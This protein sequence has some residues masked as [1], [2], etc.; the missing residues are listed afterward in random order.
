ME[1]LPVIICIGSSAV[2]GDSLG[3]LV[4]DLLREKHNVKA[5]VYG[6]TGR[7]VNGINYAKYAEY[8]KKTHP[9]S[10]IVAVDAC[11]GDAEDIGKIKISKSGISAGGALNKKLG[12][13]GDVGILG[14][15]A[16]K[17]GDNLSA[18][19]E[20]PFMRVDYMSSLIARRIACAV[21]AVELR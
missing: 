1:N 19:M 20:V 16:Q 4:G 2:S 21:G 18:L 3:P 11:V 17:S 13:I 9:N 14:I 15:V 10:L 8:I 12:K 5:F 7:P 6:C